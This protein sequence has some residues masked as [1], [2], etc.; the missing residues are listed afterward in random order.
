M[1]SRLILVGIIIGSIIL[2]SSPMM[3]TNVG[4]V[5]NYYVSV[6]WLCYTQTHGNFAATGLV[7]INVDGTNYNYGNLTTFYWAY[8]T[9]H[10]LTA[11]DYVYD[12]PHG[13]IYLFENWSNSGTQSQLYTVFGTDTV[14]ANYNTYWAGD[15]LFDHTVDIFSAVAFASAFGATPSS[16]NWNVYCDFLHNGVIDI[17]DAIILASNFGKTGP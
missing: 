9:T 6:N 17:F 12:G 10:N 5:S 8:G 15:I 3:L 1:R 13:Y 2:C 16:P 7:F 11:Y 14:T 4:A